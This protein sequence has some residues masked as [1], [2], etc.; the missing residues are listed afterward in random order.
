MFKSICWAL[1]GYT[2]AEGGRIQMLTRLVSG[3][4]KCASPRQHALRRRGARYQRESDKDTAN[5]ETCI[6]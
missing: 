3:D 2:R 6:V 5:Y 1:R 4:T